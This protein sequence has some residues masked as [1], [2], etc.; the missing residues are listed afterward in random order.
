RADVSPGHHHAF[1][2]CGYAVAR[3]LLP[4]K[5]GGERLAD[6]RA[7]RGSLVPAHIR[8]RIGCALGRVVRSRP[9]AR[10]RHPGPVG[11]AACRG[12]PECDA[13]VLGPPISSG[14][15][16]PPGTNTMPRGAASARIRRAVRTIGDT[17]RD[18]ARWTRSAWLEARASSGTKPGL[19][20]VTR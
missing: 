15:Y 9:G 1:G 3:G 18:S 13:P 11:K 16:V 5:C 14:R 12:R 20:T 7:V 19:T 4:L 2:A 17:T 6:E 8:H 10:P